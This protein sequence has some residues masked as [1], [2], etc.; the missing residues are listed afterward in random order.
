MEEKEIIRKSTSEYASPLVQKNGDLRVCTDFRWMNNRTL[1]DAHPLPHL[2]DYLAALGGNSLFSTMDL[3]FIGFYNMPLHKDDRKY[4]GFTT[5]MWLYE[6][7]RLPQ[8]L[9]NSPGSFMRMMT[10]IFGLL[11][12]LDNVFVIAQMKVVLILKWC[13]TGSEST[14]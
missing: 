7:N 6:Y 11:C 5:P 8:G 14:I 12:Y 3:T 4:S 1:K 10:A 2:A 9:C 13:S